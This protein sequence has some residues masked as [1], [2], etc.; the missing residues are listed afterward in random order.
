LPDVIKALQAVGAE[1]VTTTPDAFAQY[2]RT[3]RAKWGE[4]V[5]AAGVKIE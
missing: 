4:V 2:T 3:E 1:P 5:R